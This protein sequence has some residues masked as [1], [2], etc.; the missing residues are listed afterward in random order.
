MPVAELRLSTYGIEKCGYFT[1][2]AST[3]EFG[4]GA[5][6]CADLARWTR[7]KSVGETCTLPVD[8]HDEEPTRAFCFDLHQQDEDYLLTL[9][10]ESAM[11]AGALASVKLT[12]RVGAPTVKVRS[13]PPG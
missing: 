1:W 8:E 13:A 7:N 4:D 10:N 12:S 6:M 9:W 3:P 5:T 2:G 11:T